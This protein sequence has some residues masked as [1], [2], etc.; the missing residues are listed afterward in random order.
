MEPQ[1]AFQVLWT[2]P[3]H[4]ACLE[5]SLLLSS[6]VLSQTRRGGPGGQHRNKTSTTIVILHQPSG[7]EAEASERRSQA[8]NRR[9]ATRRLREELAIRLRTDVHAR[10]S[11]VAIT[12]DD[13]IE[14]IDWPTIV[15][16]I[17]ESHG[18]AKLRMSESN[19]NRPSV[20]AILLDDIL[21]NQGSTQPVA[22][23]WRTSSSQIVK[24]L[25]QFPDALQAV[26]RLRT[27]NNLSPLR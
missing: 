16:G 19:Q 20:L 24:F 2:P 26:N 4:P 5:E 7:I 3:P 12:D 21:E 18:G 11:Q 22:S 1:P 14:P 13:E 9:V 15:D 8:D 23:L 10:I 17:R 25:K 6:C 27:S